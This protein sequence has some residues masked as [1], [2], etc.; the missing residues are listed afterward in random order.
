M[1]R[2]DSCHCNTLKHNFKFSLL[3]ASF[4]NF[5]VIIPKFL[6]NLK[7]IKVF[8]TSFRHQSDVYLDP[9]QLSQ[10]SDLLHAESSGDRVPMGE[11]ISA[12]VQTSSQSHPASHTMGTG[13]FPEVERPGP[14]VEHRLPSR[15]E[16]K[17]ILEL[18][19]Y[20]PSGPVLE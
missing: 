2:K 6:Q 1:Y 14:D 17:E 13:S 8:L 19:L 7:W 10:Y 15:A 3:V 18:Y 16:I 11:G 5:K 9:G 4:M 12:P 20:Y